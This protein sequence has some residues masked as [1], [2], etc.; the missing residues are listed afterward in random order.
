MTYLRGLL[1][2]LISGLALT[3][4]SQSVNEAGEL[5]NQGIQY[6]KESNYEAAIDA[7]QKTIDMASQLGD[8]GIDL[9]MKA[10]QAIV[11]AYYNYGVALYQDKKYSSAIDQ[12]KI[13]SEKAAAIND[14]KTADLSNTYIAGLYTGIGNSNLKK[15]ELEQALADYR[16]A[17]KYKPDYLKAYYGMGLV[18]KKQDDYEKMK[19]ALDNAIDMGET[20]DPTVEKAKSVAATTFLNAG[21]IELQRLNY[22]DAIGHLNISAQY[23]PSESQTYYYLA[24]AYNGLKKFDE[25]IAAASMAKDKGYGPES[26]IWFLL[27]QAYEGKGET[28]AACEA[29]AQVTTGPNVDAAKYQMSQVLGCN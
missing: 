10:E 26:D 29:Y 5:F 22:N 24:L 14:A 11:S 7:Y 23:D 27:G 3:A 19:E 16:E 25:A 6:T 8:E 2:L 13:A 4:T 18:Y 28:T 12:F 20:G 21:A 1:I 17:L 9:M 15:E